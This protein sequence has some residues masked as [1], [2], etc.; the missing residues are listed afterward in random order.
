MLIVIDNI[1]IYQDIYIHIQILY[2]I[3]YK[4]YIIRFEILHKLQANSLSWHI[5]METWNTCVRNKTLFHVVQQPAQTLTLILLTS[6]G[7][8]RS[9]VQVNNYMYDGLYL[10]DDSLIL[11]NTNLL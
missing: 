2:F 9:L 1:N 5:Y 8:H 11:E 3:Y 10:R 4:S 7:G 6:T